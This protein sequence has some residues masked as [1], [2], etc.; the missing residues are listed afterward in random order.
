MFSYKIV[1]EIILNVLHFLN[2]NVNDNGFAYLT[3]NQPL[4][5]LQTIATLLLDFSERYKPDTNFE[6]DR[7]NIKLLSK[8]W[9]Q[10]EYSHHNNIVNDTK[11]YLDMFEI[12]NKF[13]ETLGIL[14]TDEIVPSLNLENVTQEVNIDRKFLTRILC[15]GANINIRNISHWKNEFH[16]NKEHTKLAFKHHLH[17]IMD[18]L[19]NNPDLQTLGMKV[20]YYYN[21][22]KINLNCSMKPG[23]INI[24]SRSD[25]NFINE[26]K[27]LEICYI[28]NN[29]LFSPFVHT[30]QYVVKCLN[31]LE[32]NVIPYYFYNNKLHDSHSIGVFKL[33]KCNQVYLQED[34][35]VVDK[36]NRLG[37]VLIVNSFLYKV[38]TSE[39]IIDKINE[40]H[41]ACIDLNARQKQF[42]LV[43]DLAAYDHNFNLAALDFIILMLICS[44]TNRCLRYNTNNL[45][46]SRFKLIKDVVCKMTPD[47]IY[48]ILT[49]NYKVDIDP[50]ENFQYEYEEA[51]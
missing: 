22:V 31:F 18:T 50:L 37:N 36:E 17:M 25:N 15:Y 51:L 23:L 13:P 49:Y 7:K 46:E 1:Q 33:C 48:K 12:N 35:L 44:I 6:Y 27:H 47:K 4:Q 24:N 11:Q 19:E 32:L 34:R 38:I 10:I 42:V 20:I 8:K 45:Y 16:L 30:H 29:I 28:P 26:S 40:Y 21:P 2:N 14:L 43:G 3:F 5:E 39:V 41:N 9:D